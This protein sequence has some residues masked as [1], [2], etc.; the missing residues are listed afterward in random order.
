M[1]G[2]VGDWTCTDHPLTGD[3][4]LIIT[5]HRVYGPEPRGRW[6][7]SGA[8]C[9]DEA[10]RGVSGYAGLY[11]RVLLTIPMPGHVPLSKGTIAFEGG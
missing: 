1:L 7:L 9:D 3:L 11:R 4:A 2:E 8:I 5:G 10:S 6:F